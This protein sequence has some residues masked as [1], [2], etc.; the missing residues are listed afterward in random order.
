MVKFYY[1][2][3]KLGGLK[4]QRELNA[5]VLGQAPA[6]EEDDLVFPSQDFSSQALV[7][8]FHKVCVCV[9][10]PI[11]PILPLLTLIRIV[12]CY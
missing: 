6:S 9:F 4:H 10:L 3:Q 11:L 2:P 12:C 7:P 1:P 5:V 8:S